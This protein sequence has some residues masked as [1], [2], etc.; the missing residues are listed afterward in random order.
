MYYHRPH[1]AFHEVML[2]MLVTK[3]GKSQT[4]I[5]HLISLLRQFLLVHIVRLIHDA[6]TRLK[7]GPKFDALKLSD[8]LPIVN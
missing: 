3:N 1:I 7:R 8:V 4:E 5:H 6:L 2:G